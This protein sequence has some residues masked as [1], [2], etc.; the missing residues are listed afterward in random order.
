MKKHAG[1]VNPRRK[2]KWVYYAINPAQNPLLEVLFNSFQAGLDA[3]EQLQQDAERLQR[4]LEIRVDGF[5]TLGFNQLE[6]PSEG[7]KNS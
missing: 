7:D 2:G 4:R 6:T 1:L 5:C 3:D